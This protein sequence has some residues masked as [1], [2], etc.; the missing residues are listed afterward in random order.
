M[1]Q[2]ISL[3][4]LGV[5][6][7]ARSRCFYERLG[8]TASG[9]SADGIA[10]FQ[11]GGVAVA[12]YDR[13]ALAADTGLSGE[14]SGSGD[15]ALAHNVRTREEVDAVLAEAEAAGGRILRHAEDAIWGGYTGYFADPDG[16]PW[17]VAWNPHFQIMPDG[18]LRL[19]T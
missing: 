1:E 17:E 10:F 8:W 19:P 5:A 12:L 4:T 3:I 2:R 15:V 14:G 6:D 16:H 13:A 7:V 18:S 11:L 9:A